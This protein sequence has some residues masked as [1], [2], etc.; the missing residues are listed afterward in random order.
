MLRIRRVIF[1]GEYLLGSRHC[2][3]QAEFYVQM[4]FI[5]RTALSKEESI[6]REVNALKFTLAMRSTQK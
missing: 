6:V 1:F 5:L 2:T 4:P 3:K